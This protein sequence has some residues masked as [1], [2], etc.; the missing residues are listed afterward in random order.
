MIGPMMPMGLGGARKHRVRHRTVTQPVELF[1][2]PDKVVPPV[3]GEN[4][5]DLVPQ[6]TRVRLAR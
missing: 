2:E 1:G 3:I 5:L 6:P 4:G